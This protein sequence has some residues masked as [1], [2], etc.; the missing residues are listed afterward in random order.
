[1]PTTSYEAHKIIESLSLTYDSIHACSNGC[2][3]F[4]DNYKQTQ[5]YPKCKPIGLWRGQLLGK[6][7]LGWYH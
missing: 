3:L 7:I 1:M 4:Q 2:V 6:P 5:V